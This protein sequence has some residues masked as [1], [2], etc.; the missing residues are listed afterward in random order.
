[1][2][3]ELDAGAV[4]S[5]A[6]HAGERAVGHDA[7]AHGEASDVREQLWIELDDPALLVGDL[8]HP[9]TLSSTVRTR[10][11]AFTPLASAWKLVTTR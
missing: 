1:M 4:V 2:L 6:M 10:S 3:G 8:A 9:R 7:R 11:A 5:R